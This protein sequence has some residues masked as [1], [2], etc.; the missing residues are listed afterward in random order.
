MSEGIT[1]F[2][3]KFYISP[4]VQNTD[5]TLPGFQAISGWIE[6]PEIGN[7]D[8]T[9]I[10]Q[11]EVTYP[12]WGNKTVRKGKGQAD[13]GSPTVECLDVPSAGRDAM[14]AAAEP[15]NQNNYAFAIEYA[16]G[17]IEYNRGL[18]MG[19]QRLKGS[20]EDFKRLAFV[21]GLQQ[22]PVEDNVSSSL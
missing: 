2:D 9:G 17:T 13:A 19:P 6:L 15:G 7:I 11:N 16:D 18:V 3:G 4:S 21:L 5:L 14:I 10:N 12:T 1:N 22:P 8:N 20:N